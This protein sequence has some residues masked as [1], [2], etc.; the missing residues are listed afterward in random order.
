MLA[1]QPGDA[2]PSR[3]LPYDHDCV[4]SLRHQTLI[5]YTCLMNEVEFMFN[6]HACTSAG[7][8]LAQHMQRTQMPP[9]RAN[10]LA[11]LDHCSRKRFSNSLVCGRVRLRWCSAGCVLLKR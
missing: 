6:V 4:L 3:C 7:K 8:T 9:C 1:A 10:A 11:P 5:T 2:I